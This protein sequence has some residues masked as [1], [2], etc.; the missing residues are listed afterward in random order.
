MTQTPLTLFIVCCGHYESAV[1]QSP[2]RKLS[3]QYDPRLMWLNNMLASQRRSNV[4]HDER[5]MYIHPRTEHS[6]MGAD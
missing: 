1:Q 2:E 5:E 3:A 4:K 6:I